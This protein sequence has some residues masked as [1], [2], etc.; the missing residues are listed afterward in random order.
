MSPQEETSLLLAEYVIDANIF[1]NFWV[2]NEDEPYGKDVHESAWKYLEEQI[3][4]G[5]IISPMAIKQ[6]ILKHGTEELIDWVGKHEYMFF[7]G[8]SELLQP[9]KEIIA[10]NPIYITKGSLPDAYIV[11]LAKARNL[12]VITAEKIEPDGNR[13]SNNPKIPNVC[14]DLSVP[15]HS[16]TGY[17]R[18]Q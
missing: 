14:K 18:H 5:K 7:E 3:E 16:V 15:C 9:L 17:F 11:A 4:I 2:F 8:L 1:I 6:E 12:S 10:K 13:S